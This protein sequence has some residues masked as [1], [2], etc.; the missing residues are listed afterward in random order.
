[1]LSDYPED[2]RGDVSMHTRKCLACHS[3]KLP[4]KDARNHFFLQIKTSLCAP[5]E[6]LVP[7]QR[8]NGGGLGWNGGG[9]SW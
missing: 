7:V 2:F 3:S 9:Y 1:M 5:D 8:L 6:Y 4:V